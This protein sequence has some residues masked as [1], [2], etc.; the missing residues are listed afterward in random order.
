MRQMEQRY[1]LQERRGPKFVEVWSFPVNLDGDQDLCE[2]LS[3][4]L[5]DPFPVLSGSYNP[6]SGERGTRVIALNPGS[7]GWL[8]S[9]L[10]RAA[11][12]LDLRLTEVPQ[13]AG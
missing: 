4:Y 12:E 3:S 11:K 2:R 8:E 9:C 13:S 10:R 7:P 1:R 5:K 6:D